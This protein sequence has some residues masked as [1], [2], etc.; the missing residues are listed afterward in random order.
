M[1]AKELK[2]RDDKQLQ[3]FIRDNK[4]KLRKLRFALSNKQL[5]NY[6]EIKEVKKDIARAKTVLKE[7]S[8]KTEAKKKT[9]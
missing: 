9:I 4:E 8:M 7:R 6:G 1:K 2:E 3:N 5:K